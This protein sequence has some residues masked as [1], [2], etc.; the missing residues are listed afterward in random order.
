LAIA[1]ASIVADVLEAIPK[2]YV[3][4]ALRRE[5]L[6]IAAADLFQNVMAGSTEYLAQNGGSMT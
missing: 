1:A 6:G 5:A 4:V 3:P 2:S